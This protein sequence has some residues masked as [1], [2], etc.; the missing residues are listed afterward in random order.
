ESS[1]V[2]AHNSIAIA[3]DLLAFLISTFTVI[4][5]KYT[6]RTLKRSLIT[7][8]SI[9][10]NP[11]LVESMQNL[12]SKLIVQI[13]IEPPAA[14]IPTT[15]ANTQQG[16]S[17]QLV[18]ATLASLATASTAMGQNQQAILTNNLPLSSHT[19]SKSE[20]I[21]QF[22]TIITKTIIDNMNNTPTSIV[23]TT[24]R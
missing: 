18:Q 9:T 15:A 24:D 2:A 12:F 6:M 8:A 16:L 3:I 1:T 23:N 7:C 19:M 5:I 13:P 17:P 4:Q 22:Y 11:R 20:D 14:I 10:N 21:E